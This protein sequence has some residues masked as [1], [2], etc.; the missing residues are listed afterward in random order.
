RVFPSI[1]QNF[2]QD[3]FVAEGKPGYFAI[4]HADPRHSGLAEI[5]AGLA[6]RMESGFLTGGLTSSRRKVVQIAD[7]VA[8]GGVS[9][10]SFSR[11]VSISTRLTQGCSP[12]GRRHIITECEGNLVFEIDGKPALEVFKQD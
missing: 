10:V 1:T 8:H 12:I 5:V 2:P 7:E 11:H 3:N 6:E 4:V 9:G